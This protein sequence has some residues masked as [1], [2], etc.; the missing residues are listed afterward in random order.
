[1]IDKECSNNFTACC[2]D[3]MD[4][5]DTHK[6]KTNI[7]ITRIG[8]MV[9]MTNFSSLCITCDTMISAMLSEGMAP[10]DRVSP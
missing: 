2:E 5:A 4:I 9:D 3:S 6:S 10:Q 7:S 1:M 8:T